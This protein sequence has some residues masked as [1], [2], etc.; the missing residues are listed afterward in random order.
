KQIG[1]FLSNVDKL[2]ES[3]R[4]E[5]KLKEEY[6][7]GIIQ[8]IFNKEIRFK[9][10][11]D[12]YYPEWEDKILGDIAN[13]FN[14]LTGYTSKDFNVGEDKFIN[15]M[16]I[17]GNNIIKFDDADIFKL[18]DKKQNKL[19][20]GDLIFTISSETPNEIGMCS[21]YLSEEITYL[22][23][24]CFGVRFD[25]FI[26]YPSYSSYYFRS[27]IMRSKIIKLAQGSTRYNMSKV[28]LLKEKI[29]I[30]CIDEQKKIDFM[31]TNLDSDIL[32]LNRKK[33]NLE[34]IKKYYLNV[35]FG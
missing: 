5:I 7:K 17:F 14:G 20:Y 21:V 30:P 27:P 31:M 28:S 9:D 8:K 24:F 22:N 29:E 34:I 32:R 1:N 35:I 11:D 26:F 23:S 25:K 10:E 19:K 15:Y 16:N 2:I 6:K 18:K 12:N 3:K 13:T 4:E 33:K